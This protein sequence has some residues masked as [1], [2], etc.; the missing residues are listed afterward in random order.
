MISAVCGRAMLR[1]G[2]AGGFAYPAE[3]GRMDG[4]EY[5]RMDGPGIAAWMGPSTAAWT[6]SAELE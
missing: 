3:C 2:G 1:G 5:G 4:A 6:E